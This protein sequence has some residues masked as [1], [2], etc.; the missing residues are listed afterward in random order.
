MYINS[1]HIYISYIN[2]ITFPVSGYPQ[3]VFIIKMY[4]YL[5]VFRY[6]K[7]LAITFSSI[8]SSFISPP[9]PNG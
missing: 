3:Y 9:V 8:K 5:S 7:Y 2:I 6:K 1:I 4:A